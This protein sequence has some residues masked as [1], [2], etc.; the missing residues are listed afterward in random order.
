VEELRM[1]RDDGTVGVVTALVLSLTGNE[2]IPSMEILLSAIV[3][4]AQDSLE[5]DVSLPDAKK[6]FMEIAE[7]SWDVILLAKQTDGA[8]AQ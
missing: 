1:K 8:T 5:E 2:V 4:L 7:L 3:N 6:V